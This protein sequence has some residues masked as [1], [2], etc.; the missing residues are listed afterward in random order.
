VG[1]PDEVTVVI[2]IDALGIMAVVDAPIVAL[3]EVKGLP[4]VILLTL[5]ILRRFGPPQY[6]V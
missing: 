2:W 6:S 1:G 4:L 3:D 5:Y